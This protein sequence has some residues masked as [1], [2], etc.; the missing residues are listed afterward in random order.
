MRVRIANHAKKHVAAIVGG[1][2]GKCDEPRFFAVAGQKII[3]GSRF[4]F[5]GGENA[6]E[7]EED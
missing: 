3:C 7:D 6:D 4:A 2:C 5:E 1:N